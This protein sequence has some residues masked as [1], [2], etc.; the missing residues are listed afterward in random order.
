MRYHP[1]G[2]RNRPDRDCEYCAAKNASTSAFIIGLIGLTVVSHPFHERCRLPLL[3]CTSEHKCGLFFFLYLSNN[4]RSVFQFEFECADP[5]VRRERED[6]LCPSCGFIRGIVERLGENYAG[7]YY[8]MRRMTVSIR[9][10]ED[11]L[12][13]ALPTTYHPLPMLSLSPLLVGDILSLF[14]RVAGGQCLCGLKS[15]G[16]LRIQESDGRCEESP[17][18]LSAIFSCIG[19][20]ASAPHGETSQPNV[21]GRTHR[22]GA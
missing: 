6:I 8:I 16:S 4:D 21:G 2:G 3:Y 1:R 14:A 12:S 20:D 10:S 18:L 15:C 13:R 11:K 9:G 5:S 19:T 22:V 7:R 17:P